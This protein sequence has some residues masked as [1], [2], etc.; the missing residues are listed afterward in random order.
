LFKSLD[1]G[2]L[3]WF[4]VGALGGAIVGQFRSL[5]ITFFA[6]MLIGVLEAVFT[7][8]RGHLQFV[9]DFRKITPFVVAVVAIVWISRRRTVT[10]SGREL[11]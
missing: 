7:P 9:G 8:F 10:L 4:V 1:Q 11:R 2:T 6:S 3:T 5:P